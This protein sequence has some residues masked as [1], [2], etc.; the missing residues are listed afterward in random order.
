MDELSI[1][2]TGLWET[3]ACRGKRCDRGRFS[4][5][6]Q[7]VNV[8]QFQWGRGI[9]VGSQVSLP[10]A[11]SFA[12]QSQ[13]MKVQQFQSG[14]GMPA[15]AGAGIP[16]RKFFA[17][18]SQRGFS[19]NQS[20]QGFFAEQSQQGFVAKQSQPGIFRRKKRRILMT[21]RCKSAPVPK[22]ERGASWKPLRSLAARDGIVSSHQRTCTKRA[23]A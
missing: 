4:E 2:S 16:P 13:P 19:A 15:R 5:R 14:R 6:A 18:Q 3:G 10:I 23:R 12:N 1:I 21:S 7:R 20:H 22:R 9:P 8:Q 17:N 11:D